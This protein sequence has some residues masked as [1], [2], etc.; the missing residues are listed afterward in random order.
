[1]TRVDMD[2]IEKMIDASK[3]DLKAQPTQAKAMSNKSDA[4]NGPD[5]LDP[6]GG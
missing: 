6:V 2:A 1:M 3:E 4:Q 5:S